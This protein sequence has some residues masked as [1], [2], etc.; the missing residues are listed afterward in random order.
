LDSNTLEYLEIRPEIHHD[1]DYP[2]R[3]ILVARLFVELP[4]D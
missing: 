3:P 2:F 4:F 1:N